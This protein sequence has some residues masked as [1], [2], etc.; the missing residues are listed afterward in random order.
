MVSLSA[1]RDE[2]R[3]LSTRL[4]A[5]S[6]LRIRGGVCSGANWP[7]FSSS[8]MPWLIR[9]LQEISYQTRRPRENAFPS[10]P[11]ER[12]LTAMFVSVKFPQWGFGLVCCQYS[13]IC[14]QNLCEL[15]R[16]RR[17]PEQQRCTRNRKIGR[18]AILLWWV[19]ASVTATN[20]TTNIRHCRISVATSSAGD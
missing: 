11:S 17:S 19:P 1:V 7:T 20:L 13:S 12:F 15:S 9:S 16:Q 5:R 6:S 4:A 3:L 2:H 18:Q 14:F 8:T 10:L